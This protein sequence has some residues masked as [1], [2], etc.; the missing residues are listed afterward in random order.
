LIIFGTPLGR[1]GLPGCHTSTTDDYLTILEGG[2]WAFAPGSLIKG[3]RTERAE[4]R[5]S[6]RSARFNG[7]N[8][9]FP[10]PG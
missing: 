4:C 3:V 8:Q 2:D 9:D 1:R 6:D 7:H 10:F 5:L